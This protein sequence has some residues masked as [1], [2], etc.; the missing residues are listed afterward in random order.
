MGLDETF[1]S[2]TSWLG[3]PA[4]IVSAGALTTYLALWVRREL[5]LKKLSIE[6]AQVNIEARKVES[7]D[8]AV[9]MGHWEREVAGL[10]EKLTAQE[11]RFQEAMTAQDK[12]HNDALTALEERHGR[13]LL[14]ADQRQATCEQERE[15]LAERVRELAQEQAD[16]DD[17]HR[18][19]FNGLETKI[20]MTGAD[21]L[22]L[23][24]ASGEPIPP[25]ALEAA[26][27]IVER[28]EK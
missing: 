25:F 11:T 12:R 9:L 19:D 18:A 21:Q 26:R 8:D 24:A 28:N 4:Q 13:A 6:A 2:I 27:Q 14:A 16:Q 23:L 10:R 1:I 3:T 5:G 7:A 22:R 20:R 15:R 17:R